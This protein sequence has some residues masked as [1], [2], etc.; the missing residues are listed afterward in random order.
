MYA[1]MQNCSFQICL[2]MH[3]KA[4]DAGLKCKYM[5]LFPMKKIACKG[6]IMIEKEVSNSAKDRL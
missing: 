2:H 5:F 4:F 1:F 6:L 3:P